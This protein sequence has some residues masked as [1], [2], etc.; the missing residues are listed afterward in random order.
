MLTLFCDTET[1]FPAEL[2][3][4]FFLLFQVALGLM[5][6]MPIDVR[7]GVC[8]DMA[9]QVVFVLVDAEKVLKSVEKFLYKPPADLKALGCGNL[10]IFMEADDVVSIH[11]ARVFSPLL[12][13]AQEA[14]VHAVLVYLVGTV[15]ACDIDIS[16]L[17]LV[18]A[19]DVCDDGAHC[20]VAF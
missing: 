3:R 20:S 15:G 12:L 14:P 7:Y 4:V 1:P 2:V 19:E 13:L 9:V 8:N 16:F 6:L 10:L 17:N 18:A 11:P 5:Q